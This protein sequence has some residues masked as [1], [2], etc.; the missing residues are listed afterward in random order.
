MAPRPPYW[1]GEQG[2]SCA[3]AVVVSAL[4]RIQ[5]NLFDDSKLFDTDAS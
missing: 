3:A 5:F 1:T 4:R 2:K